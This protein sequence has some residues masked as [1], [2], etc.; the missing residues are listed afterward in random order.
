MK[1]DTFEE[2]LKLCLKE[3]VRPD[4]VC[5]EQ[6]SL[7]AILHESKNCDKHDS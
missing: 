5:E 3:I 4:V 6:K 2:I 1:K 7:E